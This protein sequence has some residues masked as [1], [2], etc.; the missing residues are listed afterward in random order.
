MH[1][2]Q[3]SHAN[4]Q[5]SHV[6]IYN[7]KISA[8]LFPAL[9]GSLQEF[10]VKDVPVIQGI[11]INK[12]GLEDYRLS[13]KSSILFPYPNRI[14]GGSYAYKGQ[15]YQLPI[16]DVDLNNNLH[17]LVFDKTFKISKLEASASSC[18]VE[19]DYDYPGDHLGFPFPYTLRLVYEIGTEGQL[20]LHFYVTNTGEDSFPY[21]IG[22][23]PYFLSP[24]LS[25]S[26]LSFPSSRQ[27]EQNERNIPTGQK[28]TEFKE[29]ERLEN[30]FYD[31]AFVLHSGHCEFDN[32]SYLANLHFRHP[33]G[34][35][36]QIYTP[37]HRKSIA[38]EPMTCIAN[39]FTNKIGF[40]ELEPGQESH[41]SI[42]L[43]IK[44][45]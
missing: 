33:K 36:L 39:S 19:M 29:D 8:K 10:I 12:V 16:N 34:T 40:A 26:F 28:E 30:Q 35:Y 6:H 2:K 41:W 44:T 20:S 11:Q 32:R 5:L 25:N 4:E 42:E 31:D 14:D 24:D 3:I 1:I 37:P 15:T 9:G 23:H 27:I 43:R 45:K 18:Q 13:Y 38:I 22:W 21:G 7:E 17:G